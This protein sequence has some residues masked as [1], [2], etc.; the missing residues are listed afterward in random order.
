[1]YQCD[2]SDSDEDEEDCGSKE[3]NDIPNDTDEESGTTDCW[4]IRIFHVY[5]SVYI[6][7]STL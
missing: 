1:M 3:P 4:F 7:R 6:Y 5:N 2:I